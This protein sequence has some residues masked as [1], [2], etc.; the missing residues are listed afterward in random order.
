MVDTRRRRLQR[1]VNTLLTLASVL[2]LFLAL[3]IAIRLRRP[4]P[5][6]ARET[7]GAF[8]DQYDPRFGWI[9]I[10]NMSRHFTLREFKTFIET[11]EDG[12]RE[13]SFRDVSA[14]ARARNNTVLFLGDSFAWGWG[15]ERDERVSEQLETLCNITAINLA[16]CGQG[17]D[18]QL[19]VFGEYGR[20][21]RPDRVVLIL[22]RN[23]F[24]DIATPYRHKQPKPMFTY[25]DN[26]LLLTN[27]PVPYDS[28]FWQ[29]KS[30]LAQ[31]YGMRFEAFHETGDEEP[32]RVPYARRVLEH[33]HAYN[34]LE[35]RLQQL[36]HP[37]KGRELG[38]A[39]EVDSTSE[40][41]KRQS[42]LMAMILD[43]LSRQVRQ[44]G[45]EITMVLVPEK[46]QVLGWKQDYTWQR[47]VSGYCST[48][49]IPCIDLLPDLVGDRSSY[50]RID[51]HWTP[52][53]HRRAAEVLC[54]RFKSS[55][56]NLDRSCL[57]M[58]G[59]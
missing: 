48:R 35:F 11:N 12:F 16:L 46:E 40:R 56:S 3:E 32:P 59:D 27:A 31:R 55:R 37:T 34:W 52:R 43:E 42:A 1:F 19:L 18:Q 20:Q 53:G 44:C 54:E 49:G 50:W 28:T 13:E 7:I 25:R 8:P 29:T 14:D 47:Y 51:G 17:P 9:G 22:F 36:M 39:R 41:L 38:V 24:D 2:L 26:K 15:V 33:S 23:D 10:P 30:K 21:L 6:F 58:V 45:A 57:H 4:M 5:S